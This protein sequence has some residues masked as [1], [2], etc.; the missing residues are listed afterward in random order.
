[1]RYETPELSLVGSASSL[2]LQEAADSAHP[3]CRRDSLNAP[4]DEPELW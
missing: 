1:M 3:D 2:V 4:S